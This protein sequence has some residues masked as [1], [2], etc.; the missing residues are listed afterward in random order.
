MDMIDG[1]KTKSKGRDVLV[2]CEHR[3]EPA[4]GSLDVSERT[5][6]TGER[7][8]TKLHPVGQADGPVVWLPFVSQPQTLSSC[9]VE[10]RF[11]KR[12]QSLGAS[13]HPPPPRVLLWP[14]AL[15]APSACR[16]MLLPPGLVACAS[17]TSF[18]AF[19]RAVP[20]FPCWEGQFLSLRG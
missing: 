1:P 11:A 14:P 10:S 16:P 18:P 8:V 3:A 5:A 13:S 9:H 20:Q 7:S 6:G 19:W 12:G 17:P 15:T 2:V 4:E